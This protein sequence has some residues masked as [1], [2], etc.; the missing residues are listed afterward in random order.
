MKFLRFVKKEI[1]FFIALSFA[2]ASSFFVLP[3]VE[4]FS[5]IN[6]N[7]LFILFS[8]MLIVSGLKSCGVFEK[9][10]N[11]LCSKM[12]TLRAVCLSLVAM[13]FFYSMLITNDVSLIT[14]VPFTIMILVNLDCKKYIAFVVVLETVAAN[15]GSMFTPIGNP[16]NIFLFTKMN[17]SPWAFSKILLPYTILSFVAICLLILFLPKKRIALEVSPLEKN[18]LDEKNNGQE[19]FLFVCIALF[20]LCLLCVFH[21]V[22]SYLVA[23]ITAIVILIFRKNLLLQVDYMLL[24]TFCAFFI[25]TG[26]I[27]NIDFIKTF[28]K[29]VVA[30]NEFF[31]GVFAS[32]VISN[33]PS[34]LLLE[35]FSKSVKN[36]L[37]GVNVGGLGTLVASLASLISYK[38]FVNCDECKEHSRKYMLLFTAVNVV[39]LVLL[40]AFYAFFKGIK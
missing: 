38:L 9:C 36:L 19:Y 17:C 12:K 5:Y 40:C 24:L 18:R 15:L 31:V 3:S 13:C 21:L 11:V 1:V 7:V 22:P 14:F 23:S 16:Q 25:F 20:I 4:Y 34:A 39:L 27:G 10:A 2:I 35:P 32:Q 8:L 30:G 28:L 33:V 26:N 6:F 29:S 37:L